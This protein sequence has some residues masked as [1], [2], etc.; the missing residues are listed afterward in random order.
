MTHRY[1][2]TLVLSA[3]M[4]LLLVAGS[5]AAWAACPTSPNYTPDFSSSSD[6]AC[7]TLNGTNP[8]Y[9]GFYPAVATPP[10]PPGVTKVLRLTQNAIFTSGSAWFNTQQPVAG[11]FSTTFTFQL[12][13]TNTFNADGIA[14]VIQNSPAGTAAL[15]TGGT[16]DGCSIGFGGSSSDCTS[17]DGIPNSL[18]VEFDTYKNSMDPNNNHVAIQSCLT[19][20]N[21][22]DPSCQIA[23][24]AILPVT[25]ADGNVHTVTIS[26][27]PPTL[28]GCG[29]GG[30]GPCAGRLHV[31]LDN[32]DLFPSGVAFDLTAIGLNSGNA[33]VGFTAA[34]GG[35]DDNQDILSW[36]FSPD[37]QSTVVTTGAL[38]T[39]SFQNAAQTAVYDYTAKLTTGSPVAFQVKPI[40][41]TQS[42]CNALVQK[43]FWPAHCFVFENAENSGM[44]A[45]VLFEVTCPQAPGGTC[46]SS[47]NQNFFAE[48]GTNF[49]VLKAD[50]PLFTYP[51]ILGLLNPFPGWLKGDG[52]PDPLHPCT[53][54][55]T[56]ALFQSNQIDTFFIDGGHTTGKSGGT[57]SCW[58]ATYDTPGEA[59]PGIK[60]T[61]P[62]FTTYTKGQLVTAS[63]T[64]TDPVTSKN[65]ATSAKGPYL[66]VASCTQSQLP[67]APSNANSCTSS[68]GRLT[69]SGPVDTSTK[70]L[71]TFFVTA[72]DSGGNTNV[73]AVIYNVK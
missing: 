1:M 22:V 61:T 34:T 53:P 67:R 54:P 63:Y 17:G 58:V 11:P 73:N 70:G 23:D 2:P 15:D 9:P 40:L 72:I 49:D 8:G 65:P 3:I 18:A 43:N 5:T 37:A 33:W 6:Q 64:C 56:G 68:P 10:P 69:C 32:T 26:Y 71:H 57:G 66:T 27:T 30:T 4:V 55:P 12:S 25:L 14:F 28:S 42:A 62:T 52:G 21:S 16:N 36:T 48:L 7:L 31:S 47:T 51:G 50:N 13:G 24:N 20:P 29:E 60:I 46:G 38:S 35:G 19:G 39:L 44:A 45:S 41:M 59:L